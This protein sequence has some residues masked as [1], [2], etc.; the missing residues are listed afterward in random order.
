MD[1]TKTGLSLDLLQDKINDNIGYLKDILGS[2]FTVRPEGVIDNIIVSIS[3]MQYLI[4]SEFAYLIK[5]YDPMTADGKYL[6][7]LYRRTGLFRREAA[8]S[9]FTLRIQTE[10][11]CS[12]QAGSL[13]ISDLKE[14][15]LF[16]NSE[17]IIFDELLIQDVAFES[18][19]SDNINVPPV[20][21]LKI[22]ESPQDLIFNIAGEPVNVN[23][24]RSVES[25]DEFR[26]RFLDLK[27]IIKR[28]TKNS[29]IKTLS[30]Y[31]EDIS[32]LAI[33]DANS[34]ENIPA[35][36]IEIVAKPSVSDEIFANAIFA[37][38]PVGIKLS[39]NT[40]VTVSSSE[41]QD[42]PVTYYKAINVP[43]QIKAVIKRKPNTYQNAV[44]NSVKERLVDFFDT[45][46]FGLMSTVGSSIFIVPIQEVNGVDAVVSIG[47]KRVGNG[48]EYSEILNFS[49]YEIPVFS[50]ENIELID[51]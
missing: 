13:V 35:G 5:Q 25:D 42:I 33:Y 4:D 10:S 24:G 11:S 31:V 49:K 22:L 48:F 15:N 16:V 44:F 28:G 47:I 19:I 32:H 14:A 27:N 17:D 9:T 12:I 6:D 46:I 50:F 26:K 1:I 41:G 36:A 45:N 43:I 7:A 51:E 18:V 39:G 29:V 8:P 21:S 34:D 30:A 20:S 38:I 2:D 40:T 37:A 23:L 3:I